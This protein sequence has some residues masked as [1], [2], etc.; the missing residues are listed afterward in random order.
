[1]SQ[2]GEDR[3]NDLPDQAR[4]SLGVE[5]REMVPHDSPE[6]GRLA[7]A[8]KSRRSLSILQDGPVA[9]DSHCG[10]SLLEHGESDGFILIILQ[11]ARG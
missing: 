4:G 9:H 11:S 7:I 3:G 1:M 5:R 10:D 8:L 2:V 6:S